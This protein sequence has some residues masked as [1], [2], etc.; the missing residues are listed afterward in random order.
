MERWV[1]TLA[2]ASVA[3][4][5]LTGIDQGTTS[6]APT[7]SPAEHAF[8]DAMGAEVSRVAQDEVHN[9]R[10]PGLAIGIVEDGRVVYARAFGT[11]NIARRIRFAPDTE[12]SIGTIT[13]QFTAAAVLLLMQD[14]KLKLTDR[15]P[16]YIPE[17]GDVAK[18]VTIAQLLLQTSGLP[19]ILNITGLP[20][21]QTRPV[22]VP[23]LFAAVD[24]LQP[25]ALPGKA[26]AD[27]WLN[28]IIAG[29][30]VERVSGISLSDYLEQH[31]F[32][33]L[34][35][36]HSFLAGDTGISPTHALGY[37][38]T[39]NGFDP[40]K[41]WDPTR[42]GGAAGMISTVY[43][44]AKWDIEMPILLRTETIAT[45]Y[46]PSGIGGPPI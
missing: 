23:D 3:L 13:E 6:P 36:G 12:S 34:V 21:D 19:G 35:M 46:T 11:A 43:D 28:Y 27:N 18:S 45:M 10:T 41:P 37:T 5:F 31:I 22:K 2:A 39:P 32:L 8:T 26:Y 30:I 42:L 7:A 24:K 40:V 1:R 14:G 33:P 15:V 44:L 4:L 16:K 25:A 9:G 17:L 20:T 38:R 29:T